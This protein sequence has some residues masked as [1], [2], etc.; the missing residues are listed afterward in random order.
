MYLLV[1]YPILPRPDRGAQALCLEKTPHPSII[2]PTTLPRVSPSPDLYSKRTGAFISSMM[3]TV[4]STRKCLTGSWS[5]LNII[6]SFL[7]GGGEGPHHTEPQQDGKRPC[8]AGS[9]V[10]GKKG[11]RLPSEGS[12]DGSEKSTISRKIQEWRKSYMGSCLLQT[13]VLH[14]I[15]MRHKDQI[16]SFL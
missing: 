15:Y 7:F 9:V 14:K 16:D 6:R 13:L 8:R 5:F 4:P 2:I 3:N 12:Q 1:P 11:P 10:K